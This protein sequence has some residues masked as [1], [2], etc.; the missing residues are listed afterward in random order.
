MAQLVLAAVEPL[1]VVGG[2][3]GVERPLVVAGAPVV[4]GDWL[5]EAVL[6]TGGRSEELK[7]SPAI[8]A[9]SATT[10]PATICCQSSNPKNR[11]RSG[12]P[13]GSLFMAKSPRSAGNAGIYQSSP[14]LSAIK[15]FGLTTSVC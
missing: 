7:T 9:T 6:P 10:R 5:T 11:R 2:E 4:A 8:A 12:V 15:D 14:S 13:I 3:L 1:A